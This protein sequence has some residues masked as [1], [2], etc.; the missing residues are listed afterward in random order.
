MSADNVKRQINILFSY[1]EF[2]SNSAKITR[3][4]GISLRKQRAREQQGGELASELLRKVAE[5][6]N[7]VSSKFWKEEGN[8]IN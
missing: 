4:W 5:F 3:N 6:E 7:F 8:L 1:Q 2:F